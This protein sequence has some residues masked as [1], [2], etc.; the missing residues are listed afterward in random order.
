MKFSFDT[1]LQLNE[2][3]NE[4]KGCINYSRIKDDFRVVLHISAIQK[5][6]L[7]GKD[8]TRRIKVTVYLQELHTTETV[9]FDLTISTHLPILM[10]SNLLFQY[11]LGNGNRAFPKFK[12][13]KSKTW[14]PTL[15]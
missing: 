4:M 6:E 3:F 15:I 2:W 9:K 11:Y 8:D 10:I 1:E 14:Y 7:V 13:L 12:T 5:I